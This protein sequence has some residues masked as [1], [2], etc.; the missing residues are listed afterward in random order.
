VTSDVDLDHLAVCPHGGPEPVTHT[1]WTGATRG[2]LVLR[3]PLMRWL[4]AR[5]LWNQHAYH[6]T[7]IRDDLSVPIAPAPSWLAGN[8]FRV[9]FTPGTP[10]APHPQIDLTARLLPA[11][12]PRDCRDPWPLSGE[13]CNRGTGVA[14]APILGTFYDGRPETGGLPICTAMI[15]RPLLPGA[16]AALFC[17]WSPPPGRPSDVYLRAGDDG[18]GGR[19]DEQC[20]LTNDLSAGQRLACFNPPS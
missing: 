16:C 1:P 18:K 10:P 12:L 15:S 14:A 9:N 4:P 7:N 13:I 6:M 3:D 19:R 20:R 11:R 5:P 2:V 17:E 8:S